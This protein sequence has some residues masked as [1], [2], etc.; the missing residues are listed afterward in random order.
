MNVADRNE[1]KSRVAEVSRLGH[2][3]GTPLAARLEPFDSF[4][5]SPANV[6]KGYASF[7]EYYRQNYL[8]LLP[9]DKDARILV[10]SCGP[11][12]LLNVLKQAG[13]RNVL[14]IDSDPEKIKPGL[15]RGLNCEAAEGF[16]FLAQSTEP[17]DVLI[18]EQELN[19][20]TLQETVD[21]LSL[22]RGSLKPNGLLIVYGL[23]G[24]NPMVGAENLAQ[25]I[26]HFYTFTEHSLKQLLEL[27]RFNEIRVLPLKVY[28]FW[29]NP[30]NYV[31]LA[32]TGL[33]ELFCRIMFKLYGKDVKILTKK[34]MAT[35]R[36]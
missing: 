28:V 8:P 32:V 4:W 7:F 24:A 12:Y 3:A 26:D 16:D 36:A 2:Q 19:H 14:G 33:F 5:Q 25:N 27:A 31:G 13:Y 17:Y 6:E 29:K 15:S 34:I 23:N 20:L 35:C 11:G 18:P 30:L 22:C 1:Q 10:I 21:F 9:D